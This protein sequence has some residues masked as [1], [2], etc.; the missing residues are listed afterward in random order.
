M[1]KLLKRWYISDGENPAETGWE[2]V[3]TYRKLRKARRA[4]HADVHDVETA[5]EYRSPFFGGEDDTQRSVSITREHHLYDM[6]DSNGSHV[7]WEI[8]GIG[9]GFT[10]PIGK[11]L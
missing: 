1:Y 8:V 11:M 3:G 6:A 9:R 10:H 7:E 2:V 5:N 4:M